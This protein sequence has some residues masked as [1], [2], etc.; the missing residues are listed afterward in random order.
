[1]DIRS[2]QFPQLD[3]RK[4]CP[5]GR[6]ILLKFRLKSSSR[7]FFLICL[8]TTLIIIRGL[9]MVSRVD[10]ADDTHTYVIKYEYM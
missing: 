8:Q 7:L 10:T 6:V 2:K 9:I 5:S 3:Q 1:M 4:L